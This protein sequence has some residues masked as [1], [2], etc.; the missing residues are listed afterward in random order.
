MLRALRDHDQGSPEEVVTKEGTNKRENRLA[1]ALLLS[2]SGNEPC[3]GQVAQEKP[4]KNYAFLH[5]M[6]S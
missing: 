5:T 3:S 4:H 6:K 2:F 1:S